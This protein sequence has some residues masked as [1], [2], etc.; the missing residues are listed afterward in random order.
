[1]KPLSR[2]HTKMSTINDWAADM[3]IKLTPSVATKLGHRC[4]RMYRA[5]FGK[6]PRKRKAFRKEKFYLNSY[7]KTKRVKSAFM[8]QVGVY[9][10]LLIERAWQ[11]VMAETL[12][13]AEEADKA[14]DLN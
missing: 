13:I 8:A 1:M 11:M 3:G 14:G 2:K 4:A 12:R 9:P 7:L 10:R 6:E 5:M